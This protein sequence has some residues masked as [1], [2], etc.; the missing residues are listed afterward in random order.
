MVYTICKK[1]SSIK[2][3]FF[4]N[5]VLVYH[6]YDF[7]YIITVAKLKCTHGWLRGAFPSVFFSDLLART[8]VVE[9]D[10]G[11]GENIIQILF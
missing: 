6:G 5:C 8:S 10:A 3:N 1:G 4:D 7:I 9:C 11:D 2:S